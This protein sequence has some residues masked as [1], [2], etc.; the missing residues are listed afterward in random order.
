QIA[1]V[2]RND[3]TYTDT[4]LAGATQYYYRIRATNQV[5]DSD[6]SA[7]AAVATR[8]AAPLLAVVNLT[9]AEVDLSWTQ[10]GND[11]YLLERSFN[12]GAFATVADNIPFTTTSYVDTDVATRGTYAYRLTAF[13][14]NPAD[15]AV[16]G[17][18]SVTNAPIVI[19]HMAG[20]DSHDDLTGNGTAQF[21]N[22]LVRL[23][24]NLNA[25]GSAFSNQRVNIDR[26]TTSFTF[27]IH[28]G[29]NPPAD[30]FA[31]VIQNNAPTALGGNGGALGYGGMGNSVA[32]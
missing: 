1:L 31:F 10:T 5:G 16:S 26:F 9:H 13:N 6:Y 23:T 27:R 3:T 15:S 24:T 29:T 21:T 4:G 12:G 32:V 14:V 2:G 8:L 20:F 19:D 17:V 18:V 25:A 28:D 11:H 30:G 22:R 7:T